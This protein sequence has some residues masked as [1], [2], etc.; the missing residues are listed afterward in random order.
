MSGPLTY[1]CN[2]RL[3][4]FL[5]MMSLGF[6]VAGPIVVFSVQSN[7]VTTNSASTAQV[8]TEPEGKPSLRAIRVQKGPEIDGRLDEALWK[9][10]PAAGPLWQYDPLPGVEMSERTEFRIVYDDQNI[11]IG[12][13]CFDSE[14]DKINARVMQRDNRSIFSDDYLYMAFDTFHDHRNGYIFVTNPNGA[15]YDQIVS[16]NIF[17]NSQII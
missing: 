3:R 2:R 13:W 6:C 10:A 11:Y 12:I 1:I 8:R 9:E 5:A 15:R 4:V 7:A 17:L 14:P 16:N